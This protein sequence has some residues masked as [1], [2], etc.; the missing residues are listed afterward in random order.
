M[1]KPVDVAA[2]RHRMVTEQILGRGIRD[3]RVLQ[4][5]GALPRHL[6]VPYTKPKDAYRDG[7]LPIGHGQTISQPFISAYM[8]TLLAP[9]ASH[10]VLEIGT[11]SGYQTALLGMLC[12]QVHSIEI[13]AEHYVRARK[14]LAHLQFK[15]VHLRLGDGHDGW[16]EAAPFDGIVVTAAA[17]DK[18]PAR[19]LDQLVEGGRL[20]I[21]IGHALYDQQLVIYTRQKNR[22]VRKEDLAVRFVPLIHSDQKTL[23]GE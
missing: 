14:L 4:A 6:F 11:G 1:A 13:I 18:A 10:R 22:L 8:T 2:L 20:V 16:P 7:P 5:I 3:K 21:P 23:A 17:R 15:N 12:R 9:Q 19:L